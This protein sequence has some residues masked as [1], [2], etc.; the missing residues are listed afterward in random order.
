[1]I[2][3]TGPVNWDKREEKPG[4]GTTYEH[5]SKCHSTLIPPAEGLNRRPAAG[6]LGL[7]RI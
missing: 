7:T 4:I 3:Q 5:L 2:L 1:M 6:N